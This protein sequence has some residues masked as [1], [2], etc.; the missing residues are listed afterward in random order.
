[1][2]SNTCADCLRIEGAYF[3]PQATSPEQVVSF[4]DTNYPGLTAADNAKITEY[5]PLMAP[6]PPN[7]AYFPSVEQAYGESTLTCPALSI[8]EAIRSVPGA[9][10]QPAWSYHN[11]IRDDANDALG[12][13]TPHGYE[14]AAIFGP[15][16]VGRNVPPESF[17]TY[18]APLVGVFMRYW[19]SFVRG[20]E[21]NAWRD[22][23]APEW[24]AWDGKG[25]KLRIE[26]GGLGMEGVG[27][28]LFARCAFWEGVDRSL[29]AVASY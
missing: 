9:D 27:E 15:D 13:G 29:D 7:S 26:L 22:P 14:E 17:Y 19:I 16:N 21:P 4:L 3:V 8:L 28:D 24:G 10:A 5:Y 2:A 18:N 1:M 20:L 25:E 23:E 11:V 12:L 6:A